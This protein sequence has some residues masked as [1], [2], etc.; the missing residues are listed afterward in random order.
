MSDQ[1]YQPTDQPI[2]FT[3]EMEESVL[4]AVLTN[5]K[6]YF[7]VAD[8]LRSKTSFFLLRHQWIWEA[9]TIV[10]AKGSDF[11]YLMVA[12]KLKAAGHLDEVG[13]I[14]YLMRLINNTPTSVHAELYAEL[15]RRAAVRRHILDAA[16]KIKAAARDED[17]SLEQVVGEV[18]KQVFNALVE[19][20]E[21]RTLHIKQA[22]SDYYDRISA[23]QRGDNDYLGIPTGFKDVDAITKGAQRG[24]L[25]YVAGRPG[26]GKTAYL[27]NLALHA[28]HL[29]QRVFIWSGEMN[30]S[31]N[32]A[33]LI[34][35]ECAVDTQRLQV[36]D[37][38]TTELA[39]FTEVSLLRLPELPLWIDDTAGI[40]VNKLHSML[41]RHATLYGLDMAVVDYTGLLS[42]TRRGN[43]NEEMGEISRSLK[44]IAMDLNIPVYAAAQLNRGCE[45]RQDK[46]PVLRDLRDSGDLEQDANVIQFLYRDVVYNPVTE[47]P[48]MAEIIIGKNRNG[49]TGTAY[50]KFDKT[51]TRFE[52][53]IFQQVNL[54]GKG[55]GIYEP[56]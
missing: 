39:R 9:M 46:R 49:P 14:P 19:G 12:D 20:N 47:H 10:A 25:I 41:I 42:S 5:P 11:D 53:A 44:R 24:Q 35:A 17:L 26:M 36:G 52:N 50:L 22:T 40:T 33:R 8:K 27:L 28:A 2:P 38:S 56:D 7:G 34:A 48:D 21:T 6:A 3:P 32:A 55:R 15:V 31:E 37:M 45:D 30:V 51:I 54:N 29:K 1:A 4:G 18:E 43:R 13:G 23:I 16:E